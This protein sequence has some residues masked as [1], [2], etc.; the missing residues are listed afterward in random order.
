MTS[1][2]RRIT[3]GI[4]SLLVATMAVAGC[5]NN[6]QQDA[7]PTT[8]FSETQT[9]TS[10]VTTPTTEALPATFPKRD[11]IHGIVAGLL[12]GDGGHGSI[13]VIDPETGVYTKLGLLPSGVDANSG[14]F[15]SPDFQ[16]VASNQKVNNIVH[17]G[18]LNADGTFSDMTPDLTTDDFGTNVY[19]KVV[20]FDQQNRFYWSISQG[21]DSGTV[22]DTKVYR[23]DASSENP[24]KT[25]EEAPTSA[26][27][28][29]G[30]AGY[31]PIRGA[32]GTLSPPSCVWRAY[33]WIAPDTYFYVENENSN[34]PYNVGQQ[35]F[36]SNEVRQ[37]SSG[38]CSIAK[39]IT[40]LPETNPLS[41][42]Q[43]VVSPDGSKVAFFAT[44]GALYIVDSLG[45]SRPTKAADRI[46]YAV[47][48]EWL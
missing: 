44:T 10:E 41:V 28:N 27:G 36:R 46:P 25:K 23:V 33:S 7:S 19:T 35:I 40:L 34:G 12:D 43:P 13:G 14:R 24:L 26:L 37:D 39:T 42:T 2:R 4:C 21:S 38:D 5:G 16:K 31:P 6:K 11:Q 15:F 18:W 29:G 45:R 22:P 20:G 47:L 48:F 1:S 30:P 3:A 32:D 8:Y 17:S 9:A